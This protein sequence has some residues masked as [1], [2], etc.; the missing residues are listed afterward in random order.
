MKLAKKSVSF[1]ILIVLGLIIAGAGCS[2]REGDDK[3]TAKDGEKI[4]KGDPKKVKHDHTG[5][6]CEEHGVPE[7][8]CSLCLKEEVVTKKFK[9]VGDWCKLH[10]RA[11][12]QCF[13]CDPS[14]YA[15]FEKMYED[16]YG[17]KPEK[18]PAEEFTK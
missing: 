11:Q 16:K 8:L 2:N 18:P 14:L 15:R 7:K 10:D 4:A 3:K 1:A 13:K 17:A 12:S 6:W 5:W 9:D